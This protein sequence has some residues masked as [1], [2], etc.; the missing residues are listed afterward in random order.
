MI[1]IGAGTNFA[2][3]AAQKMAFHKAGISTAQ[4]KQDSDTC[5]R[6]A[7]PERQTDANAAAIAAGALIGGGLIGVAG[8]MIN[9]ASVDNDKKNVYRRRAH[10]DCMKRRG[11]TG[12]GNFVPVEYTTKPPLKSIEKPENTEDSS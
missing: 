1:V 12:K 2:G 7:Q 5:W 8:T 6:E 3:C 9:Q 11:Y 10:H 4:L